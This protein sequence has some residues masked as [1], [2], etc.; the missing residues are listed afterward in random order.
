[1]MKKSMNRVFVLGLVLVLSI[2]AFLGCSKD[3]DEQNAKN[4]LENGVS[5][6][7]N[8]GSNEGETEEIEKIVRFQLKNE[9]L[10]LDPIVDVDAITTLV[11]S[12]IYE[13][14]V[15]FDDSN[16]TIRPALAESWTVSEDGLKY[17]FFLRRGVYFHDDTY[18]DADVVVKNFDRLRQMYS[19]SGQ[20]NK[21]FVEVIEDVQKEDQYTVK[22]ILSHNY[23]PFLS[24]L[25]MSKFTP[26][27]SPRVL[28]EGLDVNDNP[29]GTGPFKFS[30]WNERTNIVLEKNMNYW[31]SKPR[32][33]KIDFRMDVF[34]TNSAGTMLINKEID[35]IDLDRPRSQQLGDGI[36]YYRADMLMSGFIALNCSRYPFDDL[37]NRL[38]VAHV[39]NR[40]QLFEDEYSDVAILKNSYLPGELKGFDSSLAFY[41]FNVERAQNFSNVA[42][43]TRVTIIDTIFNNN[44]F[45]HEIARS[46]DRVG[47]ETEFT[48][49]LTSAQ[50]QRRLQKGDYDILMF[51]WRW[52]NPDPNS[53]IGFLDQSNSGA[54][55]SKYFNQEL[56]NLAQKGYSL[57]NG[58][59]RDEVYKKIQELLKEDAVIIPM[60]ELSRT[61]AYGSNIRNF[62][63]HPTGRVMFE[64]IE[65]VE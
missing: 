15:R 38:A 23:T 13:G 45:N 55:V 61:F 6:G 21:K 14:L 43:N 50:F 52:E 49:N 42:K 30:Q 24:T 56:E 39:I 22:F 53:L 10:S 7:S 65:V 64:Y 3:A 26:I 18:F 58:P 54:N 63:T 8:E 59:E 12:N 5:E 60:F 9:P 34:S 31:S 11:T 36:N 35:V 4:E 1:M 33:D 25:A 20:W 2:G 28:E 47:V 37:N 16:V 48:G 17:T 62:R 44:S 32:I 40:A 41:P 29:I 27:V 46:L 19:N 51:A 57:P